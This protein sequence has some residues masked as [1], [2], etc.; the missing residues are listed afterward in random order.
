MI[1]DW[2]G[3]DYVVETRQYI[4][5]TEGILDDA[6]RAFIV[7]M[8]AADPTSGDVMKETGGLRKVRI[9][10]AGRGKRGGGRIITFFHDPGMPVFLLAFYAKNSQSDLNA[11]QRKAARKITE[12]ICAQ[13]GR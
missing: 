11:G 7:D 5:M 3:I 4:S 1:Y 8:I 10:L 6:Q 13:Y 2:S 12:A 9:A